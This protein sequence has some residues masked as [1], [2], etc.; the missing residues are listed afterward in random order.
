MVT[1][2]AHVL[3][4]IGTNQHVK[5]YEN[6]NRSLSLIEDILMTELFENPDNGELIS[7]LG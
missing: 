4:H 7:N 5:D 3:L 1:E 2:L 6:I